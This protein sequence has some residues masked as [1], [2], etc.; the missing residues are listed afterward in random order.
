M[1]YSI[2][3]QL[4]EKPLPTIIKESQEHKQQQQESPTIG[5]ESSGVEVEQLKVQNIMQMEFI[6]IAAHE[7]R[8]PIQPILGLSEIL[9]SKV[10]DTEQ[11][12]LLNAIVRNAKRLEQLTNDILD[13]ARIE[14]NSLKVTKEQFNLSDVIV[15]VIEDIHTTSTHLHNNQKIVKMLY[16]PTNIFVNADKGRI[17]QVISNLLSNAVKFTM[18]GYVLIEVE[19]KKESKRNN[20]DQEKRLVVISVKDTGVGLDPEILSKLFS[21]F[22]T[23]SHHNHTGVGFGLGLFI[24]KNIVEAH[25][26]KMWAQNNADGK[27][28]TFAF[29]LPLSK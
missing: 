8:T 27:G 3:Q 11:L 15:N 28:A 13:V 7:L 24:S 21:K 5:I 1:M 23:K 9:I 26:G 17:T 10:K 18:E 4:Q 2:D 20:G 25:G 22:A 19:Q 6:N 16:E 29:S 14:T 12:Q